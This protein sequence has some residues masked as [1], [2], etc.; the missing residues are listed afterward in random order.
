MLVLHHSTSTQQNLLILSLSENVLRASLLLIV[1][2][3]LA[4][5][6]ASTCKLQ[7]RVEATVQVRVSCAELLKPDDAIPSDVVN[8]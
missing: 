1:N 6:F 3:S 5:S 2:F 7:L 8:T 4:C